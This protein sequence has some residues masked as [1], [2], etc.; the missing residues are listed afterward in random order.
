MFDRIFFER[1]FPDLVREFARS[2]KTDSPAVEFLL[3]EGPVYV[4]AIEQ[5]RE[6]W[7]AMTVHD[8]AHGARLVLSPYF[9][10]K[11]IT[12]YKTAPKPAKQGEAG[13]QISPPA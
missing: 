9:S 5:T 12:F 7:L 4:R 10:I 1:H 13:F 8:E 11:R 2:Y 3:D 6:G